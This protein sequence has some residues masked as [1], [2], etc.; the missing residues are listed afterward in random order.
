M[1]SGAVNNADRTVQW[2]FYPR[3]GQLGVNTHGDYNIRRREP[4]IGQGHLYCRYDDRW[5]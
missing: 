3:S 2:G 1:R 4:D 5:G